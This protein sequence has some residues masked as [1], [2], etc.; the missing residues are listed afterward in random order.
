M[1]L[2]KR[3]IS[4]TLVDVANPSG[5]QF[6]TIDL[7]GHR[8]DVIIEN[9]GGQNCWGSMSLRI[10]GMSESN[11]NRFFVLAGRVN[12]TTPNEVSVSAGDDSGMTTIFQGNPFFC[13]QDY[14]GAPD[15][16]MNMT[17]YSALVHKV[18]PVA[19]NGFDGSVDVAE[20]IKSIAF[21]MGFTFRNNGVTTKL[22]DHYLSGSAVD[23]IKDLAN[24][25]GIMVKFENNIVTIWPNGRSADDAVIEISASNGMVGYPTFTATGLT[26]RT[27]FNPALGIGSGSV[28]K[29]ASAIEKANGIWY[30]QSVRHELGTLSPDSPWFTTIDVTPKAIY[31]SPI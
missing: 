8:T 2:A 15:I 20:A 31:G 28:V 11:M 5:A 10:F 19:P 17:A 29:V 18:K 6:D 24:A 1:T 13:Y 16:S 21:S 25:A 26:V 12:T 30:V 14:R 27:M 9:P 3:K 7:A 4:V 22:Q 23:Q